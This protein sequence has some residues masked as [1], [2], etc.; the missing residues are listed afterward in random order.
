MDKRIVT[1]LKNEESRKILEHGE[2]AQVLFEVNL[3]KFWL[4]LAASILL[5]DL[6]YY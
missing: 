4:L 6:M 2:T 5:R 3:G 1:M